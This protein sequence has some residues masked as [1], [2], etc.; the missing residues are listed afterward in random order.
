MMLVAASMQHVRVTSW[1]GGCKIQLEGFFDV[2]IFRMRNGMLPC[3]MRNDD[4]MNFTR[5]T[6]WAVG[7][8][9]VSASKYNA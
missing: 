4:L 8:P 1:S 5:G 6:Q 7:L 3:R 9:V 2:H